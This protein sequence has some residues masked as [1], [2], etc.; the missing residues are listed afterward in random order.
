MGKSSYADILWSTE[1]AA[2]CLPRLA[3]LRLG[4]RFNALTIQRCNA[5]LH[6]SDHFQ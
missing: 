4:S 6:V 5:L 2:P 3:R 1:T